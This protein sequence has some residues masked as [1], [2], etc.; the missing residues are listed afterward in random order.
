MKDFEQRSYTFELNA[1]ET[2]DHVGVITG[3]PIVYESKTDL[4]YF[5]EVIARGALDHAD[6]RDVR[7][8]VNHDT[9]KIPLA[10]SRN[11]NENSTMKFSVDD[12]GLLLD[13]VKLDIENNSEARNLYSAVKRGD[14]TGM[15]FMFSVGDEEWSNL[16]SDHPTRTIKEISNVI[17]VSAVTFPAYDD[18]S[19]S[20]RN[21]QALD[22]AR[23]ALD[24]VERSLDSELELAKAKFEAL[25][26]VR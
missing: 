12:Q 21:K 8:L 1:E 7:F 13:W 17:E 3:R 16:E 18:T 24:S 25:L 10:R 20:V 5:D 19:I 9:S 11:N 26:K 14:I 4:G 6:L 2:E 15:S 22:S 23:S